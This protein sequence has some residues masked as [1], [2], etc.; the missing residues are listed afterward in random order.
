MGATS[1]HPVIGRMDSIWAFSSR[2]GLGSVTVVTSAA[3]ECPLSQS[4]P[5][6]GAG[7]RWG[8]LF[9]Q[10]G[11]AGTLPCCIPSRDPFTG[12]GW[13]QMLRGGGGPSFNAA[14]KRITDEQ[15]VKPLSMPWLTGGLPGK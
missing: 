2:K 1:P 5:P 14:G 4:V 7:D 9:S 15:T 13:T 11:L 8:A 10:L 6:L 3:A 12:K